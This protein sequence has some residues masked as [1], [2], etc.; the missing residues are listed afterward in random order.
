MDTT[1]TES[2]AQAR[3]IDL[4]TAVLGRLPGSTSLVRSRPDDPSGSAL[5]PMGTVPCDDSDK[6]GT[7]PVNV[8]GD[9]WVVESSSADGAALFASTS[10]AFSDLGWS[11]TRDRDVVRATTSDGY[12]VDVELSPQ[13][14]VSIGGSTPCF[15]KAGSGASSPPDTI[16]HP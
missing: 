9:F 15:P 14:W 4:M 1:L 7:G 13:G 10:Q 2:V 5:S 11:S 16:P 8:Q 6:S 12:L 3:L